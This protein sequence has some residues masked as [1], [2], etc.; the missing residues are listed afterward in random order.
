MRDIDEITIIHYSTRPL[1]CVSAAM[2]S[3]RS[4]LYTTTDLEK[5]EKALPAPLSIDGL[6][7]NS[8]LG[9]SSAQLAKTLAR[10]VLKFPFIKLEPEASA[11]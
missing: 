8:T 5:A 3:V 6:I 10:T 4:M 9:I 7:K 11:D 2:C 1:V